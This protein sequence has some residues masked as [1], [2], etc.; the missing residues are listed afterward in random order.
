MKKLFKKP[1]KDLTPEQRQELLDNSGVQTFKSSNKESK[2]GQFSNY[3]QQLASRN[4]P[5]YTPGQSSS[6]NP[7]ARGNANNNPYVQVSI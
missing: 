2:F 6:D 4:K 1:P 3:A 7:Y 5:S